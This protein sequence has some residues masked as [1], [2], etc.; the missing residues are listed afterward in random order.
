MSRLVQRLVQECKQSPGKAT[1]LGVLLVVGLWVCWPQ[2]Q[3]PPGIPAAP[4]PAAAVPAA[5]AASAPFA[6]LPWQ[7]WARQKE[8]NPWKQPSRQAP[9]NSE[10]FAPLVEQLAQA[11]AQKAPPAPPA[12]QDQ[13]EV[14]ALPSWQLQGVSLGRG[15]AVALIDGRAYLQGDKLR[16]KDQEYTLRQITRRGAVLQNAQGK[17]LELKLPRAEQDPQIQLRRVSAQETTAKNS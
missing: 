5:P 4:A 12:A 14:P 9:Q 8:Q 6:P 13:A 17:T 7:Q 11:L 1:V 15:R 10:A 3:E 2:S 16:W